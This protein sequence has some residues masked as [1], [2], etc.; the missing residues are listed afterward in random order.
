ML[1]K[2]NGHPNLWLRVGKRKQTHYMKFERNGKVVARNIYDP[3]N[4]KRLPK[5]KTEAIRFLTAHI[6]SADLGE[7]EDATKDMQFGEY[8]DKHYVPSVP[9]GRG[10]VNTMN[11]L[12]HVKAYFSG[13]T[14]AQVAGNEV[15]LQAYKN[16]YLATRSSTTARD[17]LTRLKAVINHA[18]NRDVLSVKQNYARFIAKPPS[19]E[20]KTVPFPQA[21][22]DAILQ[23]CSD[24]GFYEFRALLIAYLE[25]GAR[26][27]ELMR[28]ML[29]RDVNLSEGFIQ[30]NSHKRGSK[31]SPEPKYRVTV[32]TPR[33]EQAFAFLIKGK[34]PDERL[35]PFNDSKKRWESVRSKA[36][37]KIEAPALAKYK[38]GDLRKI[39][40]TRLN[41]WLGNPAVVMKMVG[42][43]SFD[44]QLHYQ[45]VE[46]EKL[47]QQLAKAG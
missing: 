40:I 12:K 45:Q 18:V 36:A 23:A 16:H 2:Q 13:K 24:L 32:L 34:S 29:V 17:Y 5:T 7:I 41:A 28:K 19:A 8:V 35:Y 4:P 46:I 44:M 39:G 14:L 30:P 22:E 42:H 27:E 31:S 9:Q 11:R 1:I 3:T 10:Y 6:A 25:T 38:L 26:K 33:A 47:R 43:S 21:W 37:E 15:G 20:S